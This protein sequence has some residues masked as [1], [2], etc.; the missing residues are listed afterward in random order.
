MIKRFWLSVGIVHCLAATAAIA[1]T[2]DGNVAVNSDVVGILETYAASISHAS[3][4]G[5]PSRPCDVDWLI[6][7]ADTA[8]KL[9]DYLTASANY[10]IAA[11]SLAFCAVGSFPDNSKVDRI[12]VSQAY[13]AVGAYLGMSALADYSL[14]PNL[15]LTMDATRINAA[16]SLALLSIHANSATNSELIKSLKDTG[17]IE[18]T[19]TEIPSTVSSEGAVHMTAEEAVLALQSSGFAFKSKY[20]GKVLTLTGTVSHIDGS[21]KEATVT[22]FGDQSRD[23]DDRR[24][25]DNAYCIVTDPATLTKV[26]DLKEGDTTTVTGLFQP[27]ARPMFFQDEVR[28]ERCQ[29]Q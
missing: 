20:D 13:D 6:E 22:L 7:K 8:L 16:N 24:L 25:Q 28:L 18:E 10:K 4:V 14:T 11:E 21:G 27:S 29:P 12:P 17:L 2:E 15:A 26:V 23:L 3:S 19:V 9:G 1:Q 5:G